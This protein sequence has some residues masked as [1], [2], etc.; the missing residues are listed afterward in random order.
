M[1]TRWRCAVCE[2]VN[3]GGDTCTACGATVT[4]TVVQAPPAEATPG[5]EGMAA[6]EERLGDQAAT[7]I[8][9]RELPR[10]R[11]ELDRP[12]DGPDDVYDFFDLVPAADPDATVDGYERIGTRPRVRV[13]GC[14]LPI[15]L[16][17]LLALV[18]TVTLL[19]NLLLGAL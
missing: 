9:V 16:G 15:A 12:D 3:D 10:R 17:M 11:L 1:S 2:A 7:E 13:Y 8:P 6:P 18:A 19:A 14:C 5:P 4:E